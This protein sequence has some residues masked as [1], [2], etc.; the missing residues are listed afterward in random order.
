MAVL[1]KLAR[2]EEDCVGKGKICLRQILQNGMLYWSGRLHF[3]LVFN[4]DCGGRT[5][6]AYFKIF[7]HS[8]LSALNCDFPKFIFSC[9]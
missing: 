9:G 7:P 5:D 8:V 4:F 2:L 6:A 1:K 3:K